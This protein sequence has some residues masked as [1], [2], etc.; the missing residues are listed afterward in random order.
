MRKKWDK[1]ARTF[2]VGQ[3]AGNLTRNHIVDTITLYWL[4]GTGTSATREYW[5]AA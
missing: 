1:V 2:L 4:T 5:E 3:P